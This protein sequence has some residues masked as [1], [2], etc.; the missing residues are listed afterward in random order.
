MYLGKLNQP[1]EVFVV[2]GPASLRAPWLNIDGCMR[3][4]RAFFQAPSTPDLVNAVGE[5]SPGLLCSCGRAAAARARRWRCC[6]QQQK[7]ACSTSALPSQPY[8]HGVRA[9]TAKEQGLQQL[10]SAVE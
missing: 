10:E 1:D 3:T 7:A 6:A 8:Y 5:R 2:I 9:R 4:T